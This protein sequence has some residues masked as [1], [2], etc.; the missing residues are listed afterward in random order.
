MALVVVPTMK[1]AYHHLKDF[2]AIQPSMGLMS[3]GASVETS[4]RTAVII[5]GD[6]EELT[7]NQTAERI[8]VPQPDYVGATVMTATMNPTCNFFK[9]LKARLPQAPAIVGGLL[10]TLP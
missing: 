4:S 8:V 7:F 10:Q 5:D 1:N 9:A 3:I 2:V 6:A